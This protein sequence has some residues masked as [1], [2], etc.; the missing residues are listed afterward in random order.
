MARDCRGMDEGNRSL[1]ATVI[2]HFVNLHRTK[3]E[4][5]RTEAHTY[6]EFRSAVSLVHQHDNGCH[7]HQDGGYVEAYTLL[8]VGISFIALFSQFL[9]FVHANMERMVLIS[10][11]KCK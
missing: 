9:G 11:Q 2:P 5:H 7:I 1:S 4:E 8:A 10:A 6:D 3:A